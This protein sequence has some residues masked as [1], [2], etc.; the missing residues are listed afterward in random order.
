MG[1]EY[2][3]HLLMPYG[4]YRRYTHSAG[5]LGPLVAPEQEEAAPAWRAEY[6]ANPSLR[7][8][9]T[10]VDSVPDVDFDW[11]S[12]GPF[13]FRFF[14]PVELSVPP[15]DGFSARFTQIR[16]MRAGWYR[17]RLRGDDG[18][19]LWVDDRLVINAWKDQPTSTVT[20]EYYVSGGDH[21][22]RVE[23]YEARGAA[24]VELDITPI[25]FRY[26]LFTSTDLRGVPAASYHDTMTDHEWRHAPPVA[27]PRSNGRFSLRATGDLR[28][29]AG[30]YRFHARHTGG[31]RIWVGDTL[32]LDDWN[33]ANPIGPPI[34]LSGDVEQVRVEFRH[35]G[36]IPAADS[37][38]Y[39]RAALAFEW[40]EEAWRGRIH[41]DPARQAIAAAGW[42]NVDSLYEGFRTQSLTGDPVLTY[43][44]GLPAPTGASYMMSDSDEVGYRV[45]FGNAPA[46]GMGIPGGNVMTPESEFFSAYLTRRVYV[47]SSGRYQV[48][49]SSDDAF[50]VTIDGLRVLERRYGG[51]DPF[52]TELYLS[53]GV[54]D[55]TIEY[56]DAGWGAA[57]FFALEPANWSVSYFTGIDLQT[58]HSTRTVAG[59]ERLIADR[60]PA[61]G[62]ADWSAHATRQLWLPVGRYRVTARADDGVRVRVDGRSVLDGWRVQSPST[63]TAHFEHDGGPVDI[64]V[65]YFQGSGGALLQFEITPD[66]F[67]GEYYRG[68]E[69]ERAT[70]WERNPPVAYR[71]EPS[72]DFDWGQTGRH[73]RIGSDAFSARWWGSV[74][75]PVG[76]WALRLR[77][78]DGVRLF[79]DDR[80][81]IDRWR[82]QPAT[83]SE[84]I[85]DLAGARRDLR[86]EYY[87]RGGSATCRLELERLF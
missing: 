30:R 19:R 49:L 2:G 4:W 27:S 25:P 14:G 84:A 12:G 3:G 32:A 46:F 28:F 68:V 78:D 63:Y 45:G 20:A 43:A 50:R 62:S 9:A 17:F 48:S 52:A 67:L 61:L 85:V 74:A 23:Y 8:I 5:T 34:T 41:Q 80:L 82:D 22:L 18:L 73:P 35:T 64:E 83:T 6:F 51:S 31:C 76:R 1:P 38:S 15:F 11:G 7:G 77:S 26:E 29:E 40:T 60:P 69:L 16:R 33:G 86:I 65:E 10:T 58:L 81:L 47:A 24:N 55:V 70:D 39:Y 13:T 87:E 75:L 72:I 44:Y 79:L 37:H 57:L 54:H 66:G 42:P 59:L 56:A 53:R 71:F 36:Q 21:V